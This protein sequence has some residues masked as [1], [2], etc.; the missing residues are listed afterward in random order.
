MVVRRTDAVGEYYGIQGTTWKDPPILDNPSETRKVGGREF[1][2]FFD[3]DR[4]G[5]WP[6]RP[7]RP[8]YWVSNTLLQ[9]L[10]KKQMMAIARSTKRCC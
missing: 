3:G 5:W 2:L 6:G 9:T 10:S 8:T 1:E 4:S 7:R